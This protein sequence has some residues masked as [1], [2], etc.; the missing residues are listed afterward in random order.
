MV[1]SRLLAWLITK[2]PLLGRKDCVTNQTITQ[3]WCSAMKYP[4]CV[5]NVY[6]DV[7]SQ[8]CYTGKCVRS[9][10]YEWLTKCWKKVALP[11]D[12]TCLATAFARSL[13]VS[14]LPVPAGPSGAPPR[15]NRRAPI[16]VLWT[17][18]SHTQWRERIVQRKLSLTIINTAFHYFHYPKAKRDITRKKSMETNTSYTRCA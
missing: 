17:W 11:E 16:R 2:Y 8:D 1:A 3:L 15:F 12:Y 18:T 10:C 14:V 13:Q 7:F 9:I 6:N 5:L 4:F